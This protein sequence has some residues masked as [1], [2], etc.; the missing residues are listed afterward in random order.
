MSHETQ[1]HVT[2]DSWLDLRLVGHHKSCITGQN[3]SWPAILGCVM[4]CTGGTV[5]YIWCCMQ[6]SQLREFGAGSPEPILEDFSPHYAEQALAFLIAPVSARR[7]PSA[8]GVMVLVWAHSCSV[9]QCVHMSVH[10]FLSHVENWCACQCH[11]SCNL[12]LISISTWF[13]SL[14]SAASLLCI[15]IPVYSAA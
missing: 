10:K 12:L 13:L 11:M 9:N 2:H 3:H 15:N 5:W 6:P 8:F 7:S 1:T 4:L 14:S